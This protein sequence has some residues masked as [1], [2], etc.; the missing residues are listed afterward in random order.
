MIFFYSQN[1]MI[2]VFL[3]AVFFMFLVL[4]LF[5]NFLDLDLHFFYQFGDIF[6]HCFFKY[7]LSCPNFSSFLQKLQLFIF[8]SQNSMTLCLFIFLVFLLCFI[9]NVLN[10]YVF[11]FT[12]IFSTTSKSL[13]ILCSVVVHLRRCRFLFSEFSLNSFY[14]FLSLL[15]MF[16]FLPSPTS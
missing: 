13:L 14:I 12:S 4:A 6:I 2:I 16:V 7:Y 11:I 5:W 3:D 15:N 9:L 1:N 10:Y 8:Q